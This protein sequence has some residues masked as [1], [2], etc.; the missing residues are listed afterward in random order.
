ML[1]T[2]EDTRTFLLTG[3]SREEGRDPYWN[4]FYRVKFDGSRLQL[5]TPENANNSITLSQ[6]GKWFVD[7]YSTFTDPQN[8]VLRSIDGSL[9]LEMEEPEIDDLLDTG[10]AMPVPFTVKA[11]DGETDLYG[12]MKIGRAHV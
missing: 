3:V 5:L 2:D 12:L 4:H 8:R 6:D 10:W 1:Q 9:I 11:R 7:T